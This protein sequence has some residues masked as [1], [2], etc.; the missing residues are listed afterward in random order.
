M[1]NGWHGRWVSVLVKFC[2]SV[3]VS[4]RGP[5]T[6]RPPSSC[7]RVS[8]PI[9][10]LEQGY[11]QVPCLHVSQN[12]CHSLRRGTQHVALFQLHSILLPSVLPFTSVTQ[13]LRTWCSHINKVT[14]YDI[15]LSSNFSGSER[16]VLSAITREGGGWKGGNIGRHNETKNDFSRTD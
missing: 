9:V 7:P 4:R 16:K 2:K 8:H 5:V 10:N 15:L 6:S 11:T 13:S 1:A 3:S 14:Y 12:H